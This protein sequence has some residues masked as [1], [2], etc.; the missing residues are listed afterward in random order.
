MSSEKWDVEEPVVILEAR[1]AVFAVRNLLRRP[2]CRGCRVLILCDSL[3]VVM[4]VSK[5]RSSSRGLQRAA[6]Q[7]AALSLAANSVL[8][9]RWI[10]SEANPADAASRRGGDNFS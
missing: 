4:A 8:C 2:E 10:D 9:W 6:R 5:G 1:S 7:I 3:S